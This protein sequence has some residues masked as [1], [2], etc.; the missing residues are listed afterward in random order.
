[1]QRRNAL[2]S[3]RDEK[4]GINYTQ[5][6]AENYRWVLPS[7]VSYHL[8]LIPVDDGAW[9]VE[10]TAWDERVGQATTEITR[11]GS[12]AT[13]FNYVVSAL[14]EHLGRYPD[15]REFQFA[16]DSPSRQS[17]YSHIARR[18]GWLVDGRPDDGSKGAIYRVRKAARKAV[19]NTPVDV[20]TPTQRKDH[21]DNLRGETYRFKV[22]KQDY[23]MEFTVA[24]TRAAVDFAQ[25]DTSNEDGSA[26]KYGITKTGN[27]AAVFNYVTKIFQ[28]FVTKHPEITRYRFTASEGNRASLYKK[29]LER[30]LGPEWSSTAQTK[31]AGYTSFHM[32]R[33]ATRTAL[34]EEGQRTP[35]EQPGQQMLSGGTQGSYQWQV[36]DNEYEMIFTPNP[37]GDKVLVD[38]GIVRT[39][40]GGTPKY[41][42]YGATKTGRAAEVFNY[43]VQAFRSYLKANPKVTTYVFSASGGS[44]AKLYSKMLQRLVGPDWQVTEKRTNFGVSYQLQKNI[45]AAGS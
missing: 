11:S 43:V 10:F 31:D 35:K 8:S 1:M 4:S 16:A 32:L 39:G 25:Y 29:M 37:T 20:G 9:W 26:Y 34:F 44:R 33:N 27:A 41:L 17:L 28:D 21:Q 2:F 45:D 36:G 14:K 6:A 3:P 15:T 42:E 5:D 40:L 18:L 24:G 23:V 22:D 12:A 19:F 38:F 30:L 13:V 7:G